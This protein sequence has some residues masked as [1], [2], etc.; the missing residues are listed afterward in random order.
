MDRQWRLG[1]DLHPKDNMLDGFTFEDLILSLHHR[2][3]VSPESAKKE[4]KD[5]LESRLEDMYF[6][7]DNNIDIIIEE[8]LKGRN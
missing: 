3:D 7:F 4:L 1:E 2:S 6:L 5:I 8:A